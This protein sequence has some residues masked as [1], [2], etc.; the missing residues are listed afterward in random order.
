V[1]N[2]SP[3]SL[4]IKLVIFWA[5]F[6]VFHFGY[7][8]LPSPVM[9]V[10]AGTSEGAAQHIKMSFWAYLIAS[11]IEYGYLRLKGTDRVRFL[12]SRLLGLLIVSIGT[13]LWYI[14]PAI[15]GAGLPNEFIEILYANIILLLVGFGTLLLERD[16]ARID[17]S[18]AS[19]IVLIVFNL[20]LMIILI[21]GT[22]RI[23]WGGFWY[24]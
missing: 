8:W 11:L 23:P 14:L 9:A 5:F 2:K 3:R 7:S 22:F 4:L 15:R 13:F 12:D 17:F 21:L 20:V 10:F 6:L 18:R 24:M 16:L 1:T 19:R